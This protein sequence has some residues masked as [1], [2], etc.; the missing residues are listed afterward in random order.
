MSPPK[1]EMFLC[2]WRDGKIVAEATKG[3]KN[4]LFH[5]KKIQYYTNILKEMPSKKMILSF[6]S[7]VPDAWKGEA[8]YCWNHSCFWSLI[9][10]DG[11]LKPWMVS[12]WDSFSYDM[13][14]MWLFNDWDSSNVLVP[15]YFYDCFATSE[16]SVFEHQKM[17]CNIVIYKKCKLGHSGD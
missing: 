10:S 16:R 14:M 5:E 7:I 2:K 11:S 12:P 8:M 3:W 13:M 9:R 1:V 4:G 6:S 15:F 17:V